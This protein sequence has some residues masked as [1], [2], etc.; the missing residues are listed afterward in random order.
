MS[1]PCGHCP[2][3]IMEIQYKKECQLRFQLRVA[4]TFFVL[5]VVKKSMQKF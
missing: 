4:I 1:N 3:D 5:G 2:Y